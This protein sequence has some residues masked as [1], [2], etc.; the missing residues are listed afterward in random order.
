MAT[1]KKVKRA[2]A[3]PKPKAPAERKLSM[4]RH[5][6]ESLYKV[7]AYDGGYTL[8]A[9]PYND[10]AELSLALGYSDEEGFDADLVFYS[11]RFDTRDEAV[12]FVDR[13]KTKMEELGTNLSEVGLMLYHDGIGEELESACLLPQ[14]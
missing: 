14:N 7:H 2:V 6:L 8:F 13:L 11:E 4:F 5:E 9:K 12:E 10:F 3:K 1:K